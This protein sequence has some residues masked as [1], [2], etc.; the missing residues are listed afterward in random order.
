MKVTRWTAL[1]LIAAAAIAGFAIYELNM[2]VRPVG[3]PY[4]EEGYRSL[5]THLIF[6]R[7]AI[8][9]FD[10]WGRVCVA[11]GY[12]AFGAA[13]A[14]MALVVLR[15]ARPKLRLPVSLMIGV[16]FLAVT[17]PLMPENG[18]LCPQL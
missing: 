15:R 3:W 6:A 5:L 1:C 4:N 18:V 16:L 13:S 11:A 8:C 7:E 2:R 14:S 10:E 12:V 9:D 17:L